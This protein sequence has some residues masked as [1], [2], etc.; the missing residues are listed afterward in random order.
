MVN[1]SARTGLDLLSKHYDDAIG[2]NIVFFLPDSEEDFAS[3]TEFLRYLGSRDRAGV[4]KFDDGTT[5]F[6]V[7]PSE[8][9]TKVLKI[10]GPPR[11]YGVV[12][13]FDQA[14]PTSTSMN[15]PSIHPHY[16]DPHKMTSLQKEFSD[17][18]PQER[19]LPL[20][21]PRVFPDESKLPP[22]TL[23]P[24]ASSFPAHSAPP[25]TVASQASL[26]LTPELIATLTSLLP[27]TNGSSGAQSVSL[28]QMQSMLGSTPN[29]AADPDSNVA[30]WK[31]GHQALDNNGQHVQQLSSQ[32]NSQLQH[33]PLAQ[34]APMV[35]N[36]TSNF[37]QTLSPYNQ[38]HER[39]INFPPQGAFSSN[40]M[41]SV[42]PLQ[43]GSFSVA[44]QFNQQYQQISSQDVSRG[45][46]I[47]NGTDAPRSYNS[48]NVQQQAYPVASSNQVQVH[49]VSVVQPY[50]PLPPEA[51]LPNQSQPIQ[52][53]QC[54]TVQES[55]EAEADKNERYKTT[56]LFAANLLSRI[57]QPPA[58]QPGQGAG[59]H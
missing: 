41:T 38:M 57:H 3:Y 1:C 36:M 15:A 42:F 13:K 27:A 7:P 40:P 44:P 52:T 58:S 53:A 8:F 11:L 59:S 9:L 33:Q 49:D 14:G 23:G 26:A 20:D 31:H 48:P 5:L 32:M 56:L 17:I 29:F 2:F 21:N 16:A 24:V 46:G 37:H 28:S 18:P 45:Q 22:K 6:L 19:V 47:D 39:T 35:S 25:T 10:S 55:A 12:L 34:S 43:N 51:E 4:A 54:G 50:M 30:H